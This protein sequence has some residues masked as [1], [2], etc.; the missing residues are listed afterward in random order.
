MQDRFF[1]FSK[2]STICV[3]IIAKKTINITLEPLE[4]IFDFYK[5]LQNSSY[6][7]TRELFKNWREYRKMKTSKNIEWGNK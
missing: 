6:I 5:K 7:E 3:R 2:I 4:A 1:F